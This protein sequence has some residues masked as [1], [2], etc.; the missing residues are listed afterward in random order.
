MDL[1]YAVATLG[2]MGILFGVLLA[3]A[4]KIFA[5]EVDERVEAVQEVLPGANC[6]ACGLAGC[7][8]FAEKV[9]SGECET[10][11]CIPGGKEV[12]EKIC[13]LLGVESHETVPKVAVVACGGDNEKAAE[14]FIYGGDMD[15]RLAHNLWEGFKTCK[16]G[17]LGLGTCA[18]VCPFEAVTMGDNGLPIIDEEKCT[19]CGI[20]KESCPRGVIS[21]IPNNYTG[22]LVYCNSRDKGKAV[23][24]ACFVGCNACRACVKACPQEAINMEDN[25]PVIDMEKCDGCGECNQKCKPGCI[26]PVSGE[27]ARHSGKAKEAEKV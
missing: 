15:C 25:L 23:K 17:C 14:S 26:L 6:G 21:L 16:Y 20:C 22:H 5:V 10:T 11:A 4:A 27:Q 1:V 12:A 13:S 2:G 8:S 9:V 3:V 24:E 18:E 7:S 19:G